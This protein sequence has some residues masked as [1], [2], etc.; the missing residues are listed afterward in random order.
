MAGE[1]GGSF[2]SNFFGKGAGGLAHGGNGNVTPL[3]EAHPTQQLQSG[4]PTQKPAGTAGEQEPVDPLDSHLA[5]LATL[6][7]TPTDAQGKPIAPPADPL[8]QPLFNYKPE[9]VVKK[10]NTL[11]FTQGLNPE[12]AQKALGGDPG[13][14]AEFVN[15]AV[16]AAF[17]GMTVNTAN[18]LNDGFGRHNRALDEALPQ[19]FRSLQVNT[20]ESD[21]PILSSAAVQPMYAA[22]KAMI[23]NQFPHKKPEEV[24]A[25]T[26]AYFQGIGK[27]YTM[28]DEQKQQKVQQAKEGPEDWFKQMGL[29]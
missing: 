5:E 27:A 21:D 29:S 4:Q 16:R 24:K 3:P 20:S 7:K 23:A 26:D 15:G 14:L 12:L 22:M 1:S 18:M 11:D 10:V 8:S 25:A 19:R 28:T 13:A 17:T 2:F 6:W 9:D